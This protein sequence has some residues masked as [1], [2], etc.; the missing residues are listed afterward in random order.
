MDGV[1]LANKNTAYSAGVMLDGK[2]RF[3]H[4]AEGFLLGNFIFPTY[5][6]VRLL[7]F[8]L[9][10]LRLFELLLLYAIFK[11]P[12]RKRQFITLVFNTKY[13][14]FIMPYF[15]VAVYTDILQGAFIGWL[16]IFFNGILVFFL[17]LYLGV[18]EYTIEQLGRKLVNYTW[19]LCLLSPLELLFGLS[20]FALLD[21][22]DK[23][24]TRTRF[25]AV[26]IMGNAR[27]TNGYGMYL[28]LLLP[29]VCIDWKTKKI[30][31]LNNP[32]LLILLLLNA[33]L[34]GSR[35]AIGAAILEMLLI[36]L[37]SP[38]KIRK[39]GIFWGICVAAAGMSFLFATQ[40]FSFSRSLLMTIFSAVDEVFDTTISTYYGADAAGLYNSS[41]YRELLV[42]YTFG[43][44]WLNPL[45]GRGTNYNLT[46]YVEGTAI[47]SADN[48]YVG[49]YVTY[50]WPGVITMV[51][52]GVSFIKTAIANIFKSKSAL[53]TAVIVSLLGYY[54][55]LWYL[56]RLQTFPLMLGL[57]ALVCA[58]NF[59]QEKTAF[60]KISER[61]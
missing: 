4:L 50:A 48:F 61:S 53:A 6:G 56:D 35:L 40:S 60:H 47:A 13:F 12:V 49:T 15:I 54:A 23:S 33:V 7:G 24:M 9:T 10:V 18:Y 11:N 32:P 28:M 51:Y 37:F 59:I 22:L 16:Y 52:I 30:N 44:T 17:C 34:T 1:R 2:I 58:E 57:G 3:H 31:L 55:S 27:T 20:P 21:T 5:F 38:S 26:R 45:L 36:L 8:D 29:L 46:L 41:H 42:Q 14:W 39:W 25:G 43:G 19:V